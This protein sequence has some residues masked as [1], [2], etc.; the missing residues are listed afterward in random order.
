MLTIDWKAQEDDPKG[1]NVDD[2]FVREAIEHAAEHGRWRARGEIT[3]PTAAPDIEVDERGETVWRSE[4][5]VSA[6]ERQVEADPL[7]GEARHDALGR[8]L[9]ERRPPDAE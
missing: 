4:Q 2:A 3:A 8:E 5:Q 6:P 9:D 7:T 1:I